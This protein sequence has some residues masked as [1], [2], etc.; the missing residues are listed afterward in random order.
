MIYMAVTFVAIPTVSASLAPAT[1]RASPRPKPRWPRE[2][3]SESRRLV[4]VRRA[5][6]KQ[7]KLTR[8]T[9]SVA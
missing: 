9:G 3:R 1:L 6:T 7:T 2:R 5:K 4:Q 8:R